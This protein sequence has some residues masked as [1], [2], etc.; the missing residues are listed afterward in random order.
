M[1]RLVLDATRELLTQRGPAV[2]V[3]EI[4]ERAG[5]SRTVLFRHFGDKATLLAEAQGNAVPEPAVD[6]ART[7]EKL[8]VAARD[9]LSEQGYS[10]TSTRRIAAAVVEGRAVEFWR[11]VMPSVA[12]GRSYP[13][14]DG[15]ATDRSGP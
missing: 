11:L 10:N 13:E 2:T 14:P 15:T 6:A 1:H 5:V 8:R 7:R 4:A 3:A 12:H 9:L